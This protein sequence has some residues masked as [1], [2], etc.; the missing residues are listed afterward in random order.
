MDII[1]DGALITIDGRFSDDS[2]LS[3]GY[4]QYIGNLPLTVLYI[5]ISDGSDLCM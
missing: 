2:N 5:F 3:D 1:S 4:L